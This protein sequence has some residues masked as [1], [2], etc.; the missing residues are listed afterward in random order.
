MTDTYSISQ[1]LGKIQG[2]LDTSVPDEVWVSGEITSWR[3]PSHMTYFTLA[4][5]NPK[6]QG[7]AATLSVVIFPRERYKIEAILKRGSEGLLALEDGVNVR[8]KGSLSIY[9]P[10]GRLQLRMTS[11][12]PSFTIG[13]LALEKARILKTL[14]AE[15][16]LEQNK[17]RPLSLLPLRIALISSYDSAAYN[18][19]IKQL[20]ESG[21]GWQVTPLNT[22]VQGARSERSIVQAFS[23]ID[24]T[25]FDAVILARGGGSA[26]DLASFDTEGIARAIADC[27]VPVLTG[28]GHE[29]DRSVA[30]EAAHTACKTP[31]ACAQTLIDRVRRFSDESA[32]LWEAI[33][34]NAQ[35]QLHDN[36][37]K[38]L[39]VGRQVQRAPKQNIA[40]ARQ[41][42]ASTPQRVTLA[43]TGLL[44]RDKAFI[45][46]I[47]DRLARATR[48]PLQAVGQQLTADQRRLGTAAGNS[49]EKQTGELVSFEARLKALDPENIMARGWSITRQ[50]DGSVVRSAAVVGTGDELTTQLADGEVTSS[51][52]DTSIAETEAGETRASETRTAETNTVS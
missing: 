41:F 43:T 26:T 34:G 1:L 32:Q 37:E 6:G 52:I 3:E 39:E 31:T 23:Y 30:D 51:V 15:G 44:A 48:G 7:F 24:R 20:N 14:G 13:Q 29:I 8:I 27:P 10:Q 36:R 21:F 28:I 11:I 2:V 12:D 17:K 49:L 16:L 5:P 33:A 18:D 22:F 9:A 46:G 19:V 47:P 4:E 50:S 35:W 40:L 38:L 45:A 42:L 25:V